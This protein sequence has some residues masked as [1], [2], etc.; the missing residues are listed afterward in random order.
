[1]PEWLLIVIGLLAAVLIVGG[2]IAL[3]LRAERPGKR[4]RIARP[5][6][7]RDVPQKYGEFPH[8]PSD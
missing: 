4:S 5:L 3:S 7:E 8:N 6:G 1:M 2:I